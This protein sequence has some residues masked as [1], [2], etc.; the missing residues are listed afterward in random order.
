MIRRIR[1]SSSLRDF[2][3][4]NELYPFL[5]LAMQSYSGSNEMDTIIETLVNR[6]GAFKQLQNIYDKM[7]SDFDN[8]KI[9]QAVL[10]LN[11]NTKKPRDIDGFLNYIGSRSALRG[12]Y[13]ES[14]YWEHIFKHLPRKKYESMLLLNINYSLLTYDFIEEITRL[15]KINIFQEEENERIKIL[16]LLAA[17]KVESF[18]V[19]NS[20]EKA[21]IIIMDMNPR[22]DKMKNIE[23]RFEDVR[24]F[25][26]DG[27]TVLWRL[28][29][30]LATSGRTEQ[31]RKNIIN[32]NLLNFVV[33]FRHDDS[34]RG[35]GR[36]MVMGLHA[37]SD[38]ALMT[39]ID[40]SSEEKTIKETSVESVEIV[41][42]NNRLK[43]QSYLDIDIKGERDLEDITKSLKKHL[44]RLK[45]IGDRI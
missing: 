29:Y 30:M 7:T 17:Y 33:S 11:K 6:N 22:K 2:G 12:R 14:I 21:D 9:A 20:I 40:V 35:L 28:L 5:L 38:T 18:T 4:K 34:I 45:E 43:V 10:N 27:A 25:I 42:N 26:E 1:R 44:K 8:D 3:E 24:P 37:D 41:S 39:E 23:S 15:G 32:D 13:H 16:C 36:Y 31:F 19:S